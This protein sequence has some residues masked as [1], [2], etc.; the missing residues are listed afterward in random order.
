LL[1]VH[2][3][4]ALHLPVIFVSNRP[5]RAGVVGNSV[6]TCLP[7]S[8]SSLTNCVHLSTSS[9]FQS[10]DFTWFDYP[11]FLWS[12]VA[13]LGALVVILYGI[14]KGVYVLPVPVVAAY[15]IAACT[16]SCRKS[17]LRHSCITSRLHARFM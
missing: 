1:F 3:S 15:L 4:F 16:M 13:T 5:P 10:D 9:F 11:R 7:L 2:V 17:S 14:G 12:T 6:I 8:A